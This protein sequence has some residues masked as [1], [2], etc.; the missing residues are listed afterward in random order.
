MP[1]KITA[2]AILKR[3][4]AHIVKRFSALLWARA[5]YNLGRRFL[6][7]FN[8]SAR[9]ANEAGTRAGDARREA[10]RAAR[11]L[12]GEKRSAPEEPR[13][14]R[15]RLSA[16]PPAFKSRPK[17]GKPE[18]GGAGGERRLGGGTSG[19]EAGS[20]NKSAPV[21]GRHSFIL[22]RRFLCSTFHAPQG[23]LIYQTWRPRNR[24]TPERQ[25]DHLSLFV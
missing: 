4:F 12:E 19:R 15:P 18:R 20:R 23:F 16:C 11:L 8:T 3:A 7:Y 17:R 2:V 9:T 13:R 5:S 14:E 22:L 1:S 24:S 25:R 21:K 10:G 6:L